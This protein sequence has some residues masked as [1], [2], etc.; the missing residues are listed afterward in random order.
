MTNF[1][2]PTD[3]APAPLR[4]GKAERKPIKSGGWLIHVQ[5][6]CDSFRPLDDIID[7]LSKKTRF[8][9][10]VS[11]DSTWDGKQFTW[12]LFAKDEDR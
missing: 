7:F 2:I 3:D 12:N 6:Y 11:D 10:W 1:I 9:N 5:V 8:D 4:M